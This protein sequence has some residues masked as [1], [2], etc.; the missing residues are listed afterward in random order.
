[1]I[2]KLFVL[3]KTPSHRQKRVAEE[4]RSILSELF[5]RRDFPLEKVLEAPVTVTCVSL[6][7]D[8]RYAKVFLRPL[9]KDVP[10]EIDTFQKIAWFFRKELA[11]KL[12]IKFIPELVFEKDLSFEYSQKLDELFKKIKI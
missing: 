1:M 6:S 9:S 2:D 10:L 7:P 12:K 3:E 5:V 11:K 4:I 8:L